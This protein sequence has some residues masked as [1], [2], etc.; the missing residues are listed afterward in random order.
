MAVLDDTGTM[1]L[2]P[3]DAAAPVIAGR[4]FDRTAETGDRNLTRGFRATGVGYWSFY[5]AFKRPVVQAVVTEQVMAKSN[6]GTLWLWHRRRLNERDDDGSPFD[7]P[8]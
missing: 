6:G 5:R 7:G 1:P 8:E 2:E 3:K 4:V